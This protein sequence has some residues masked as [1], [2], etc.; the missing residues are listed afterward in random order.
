ME[1]A[2]DID[3]SCVPRQVVR[4]LQEVGNWKVS[5]RDVLR[6]ALGTEEPLEAVHNQ[7]TQHF[8]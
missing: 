3:F 7:S 8:S 1:A 5:R 2:Q 4:D 6:C